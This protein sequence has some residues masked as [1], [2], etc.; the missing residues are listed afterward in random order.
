[1]GT[2]C[3]FETIVSAYESTRR[4]NPEQHRLP[5]RSENLKSLTVHDGD[6]NDNQKA[7]VINI[8]LTSPN[9]AAEWLTLLFRIWE[10]PSLILPGEQV[11]WRWLS[12]GLFLYIFFFWVVAPCSLV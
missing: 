4:H 6:D 5:H 12:P 2:V 3:F 8:S 9:F 1:M 11:A 10:V 7:Y